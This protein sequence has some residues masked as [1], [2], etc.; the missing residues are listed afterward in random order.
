[1]SLCNNNI[2]Q[3]S[4]SIHF[5]LIKRK[6]RIVF[7][8]YKT[9]RNSKQSNKAK[10][11]ICSLSQNLFLNNLLF[12][13]E[14]NLSFFPGG[15]KKIETNEEK[16]KSIF[17]NRKDINNKNVKRSLTFNKKNIL[18]KPILIEDTICED[19]LKKP[20]KE[21]EFFGKNF[22]NN[23]DC[24]NSYYN[25]NNSNIYNNIL[26]NMNFNSFNN[27]EYVFPNF[28]NNIDYNFNNKNINVNLQN[29]FSSEDIGKNYNFSTDSSIFKKYNSYLNNYF[30]FYPTYNFKPNIIIDEKNNNNK[31]QYKTE[32]NR[33]ILLDDNLNSSLSSSTCQETTNNNNEKN[34]KEAKNNT[35]KGRKTKN[36]N[37]ESKHTKYSSD[38]MMRK[39]KNKSIEA[40]RLLI[41]KILKDEFKKANDYNFPYREFKKIKGSFIQELNIKYNFWFYQITIKDI[42][43]LEVSNKYSEVQKSS[44]KEII[45][46]LY[47][48]RNKDKFLKSKKL[49]DT[50][51]HQFYHD[52][53]LGEVQDW[54]KIY[55]VKENNNKFEIEYLLK[56]LEEEKKCEPNFNEKKY[57]NDINLLAHN[58]EEFFLK[59]K[60]RNNE[61][62]NK[63]SE[64]KIFSLTNSFND[65]FLKLAEQ[66]KE[67]KNYYQNR[68]ILNKS[69]IQKKDEIKEN[70]SNTLNNNEIINYINNNSKTV[71]KEEENKYIQENRKCFNIEKI[72]KKFKNEINTEL[73]DNLFCNRKR[74]GQKMKYF[75]ICKKAKKIE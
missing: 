68:K 53:F 71:L 74:N 46:Y 64:I 67:L 54:K 58:Y 30:N 48:E 47:S 57:V 49:L 61:F 36:S 33:I 16:R 35:I 8:Y 21:A 69:L 20:K 29:N 12:S 13:K 40:S 65:E 55:E 26:N 23:Y 38:N 18:I 1:M 28:K 63:K 31:F 56:N 75:I 43:C 44:N 50:P 72:L 10:K 39:I 59:K 37:T 4:N 3:I 42:F 70:Q 62:K 25:Y 51:F 5:S 11:C 2:F 32:K 19:N 34:Y 41:N 6:K 14:I 9:I 73:N 52:I 24:F 15:T 45:D 27:K 7:G 17:E 22:I 66:I 60:P